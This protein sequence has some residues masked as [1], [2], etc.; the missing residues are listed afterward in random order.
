MTDISASAERHIAQLHEL[1]ALMTSQG[2]AV[3]EHRYT[4]LLMGS[5][6]IVV[7][8]AHQ[9]LKFGWDGREFFLN[10]Q[11]CL[12]QSQSATPN[13]EQ[14]DNLRISPSQFVW[15]TIRETCGRAFGA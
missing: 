1:Q 11:A 9:R 3:L 12:C 15:S 14:V 4:L 10:I 13:W 6:S 7:G 5:F 2:A 8:T